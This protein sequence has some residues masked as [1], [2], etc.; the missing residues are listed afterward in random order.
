M[1]HPSHTYALR[2]DCVWLTRVLLTVER[3]LKSWQDP[4]DG[5]GHAN[6]EG[7][8]TSAADD[9]EQKE[10]KDTYNIINLIHMCVFYDLLFIPIMIFISEKRGT[11]M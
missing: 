8:D 7:K 10:E 3:A 1:L 9:R 4:E 11:K 5:A 6:G 2:L